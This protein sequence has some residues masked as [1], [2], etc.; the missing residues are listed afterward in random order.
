MLL[1]LN[2]TSTVVFTWFEPSHQWACLGQEGLEVAHY[3]AS[4]TI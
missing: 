4:S 2:N 3:P 1:Y